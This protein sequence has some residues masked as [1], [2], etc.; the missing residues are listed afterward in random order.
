[1]AG[2]EKSLED[3][4]VF[5]RS[6]AARFGWRLIPDDT[7]LEYLLEGLL[8]NYERYGFF[9]CPCR[10]SWGDR[11]KDRDI[12]CPCVYADPDIREYGRC[13]CNLFLSE[14]AARNDPDPRQI[15]ER[16]PSEY[17]PY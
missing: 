2:G 10:D 1:V 5:A 3:V 6:A 16:R 9:Q 8:A 17:S 15:P 7:F 13:F 12:A 11:T 4:R 14:D